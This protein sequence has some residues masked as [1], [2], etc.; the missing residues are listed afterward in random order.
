MK[1]DIL[2]YAI[3]YLFN[4]FMW[5]LEAVKVIV[6]SAALCYMFVPVFYELKI[7]DVKIYPYALSLF[8]MWYVLGEIE[9]AKKRMKE[10]QK[11]E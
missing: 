8:M 5:F 6:V 4:S 11:S 7:M 10:E 2:A 9:E 1:K 3:A